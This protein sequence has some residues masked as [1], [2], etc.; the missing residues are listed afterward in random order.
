MNASTEDVAKAALL[1]L[2][3]AKTYARRG[4]RYH[5]KKFANRAS[6]ILADIDVDL[7]SQGLAAEIAKAYR[8]LND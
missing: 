7:L 3:V 4:D 1:R 5:A 8:L 6:H 2:T